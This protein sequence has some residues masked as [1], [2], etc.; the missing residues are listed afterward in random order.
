LS[1]DVFAY[2]TKCAIRSCTR[3]KGYEGCHQCK[4]FP[5]EH[6]QNFPVPVGK[7]VI[8]RSVPER[9]SV[10]TERWVEAEEKRYRCLECGGRTFRGAKRCPQ[11]K[12]EVD[13]D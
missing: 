3:A 5:C 2:C 6:I 12:A 1:D 11:C 13:L 9:R 4:E 10:G 7:K 8:L